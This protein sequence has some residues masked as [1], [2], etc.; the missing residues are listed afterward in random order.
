MPTLH[1][2]TPCYSANG[3]PNANSDTPSSLNSSTC[4]LPPQPPPSHSSSS[5]ALA[6]KPQVH[7]QPHN[8]LRNNIISNHIAP[9][10]PSNDNSTAIASK[11]ANSRDNMISNHLSATHYN[12]MGP[13]PNSSGLAANSL[14]QPDGQ[15]TPQHNNNDVSLVSTF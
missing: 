12:T 5:S 6:Q 13:V 8:V 11:S 15:Q 1:S 14:G 7:P 10:V 4:S 9:Q 2:N 3:L